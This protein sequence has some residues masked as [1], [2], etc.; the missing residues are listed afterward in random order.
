MVLYWSIVIRLQKDATLVGEK[1]LYVYGGRLLPVVDDQSIDEFIDGIDTTE[2]LYLDVSVNFDLKNPAWNLLTADNLIAFHSMSIGGQNNNSLIIFGGMSGGNAPPNPLYIFDT[3]SKSKSLASK[4]VTT[5]CTSRVLHTSVTKY[6]SKVFIL[7]GSSIPVAGNT[8]VSDAL[9]TL[10]VYDS[11]T[12]V[13]TVSTFANGISHHTSTLLSDDLIYVIGGINNVVTV[14]GLSLLPMN[15]IN[16]YDTNLNSWSTKTVLGDNPPQR[17]GHRAVGTINKKIIIYG[18]R[19][20]DASIIYDDVLELDTTTL[21]WKIIQTGGIDKPPALFDHTM[22]M[23]G[24]NIIITYGIISGAA[25]I[26][27]LLIIGLI[28]YVC[29]RKEKRHNSYFTTPYGLN[30][31]YSPPLT[32]NLLFNQSPN[33]LTSNKNT[34]DRSTSSLPVPPPP[35]LPPSTL[36]NKNSSDSSKL[37]I[38]D[39]NDVHRNPPR[40]QFSIDDY[41]GNP[42][43]LPS[44][45]LPSLTLPSTLKNKNSF[46]SN[47]LTIDDPNDASRNSSYLQLMQANDDRFK[48]S[49]IA[50]SSIYTPSRSSSTGSSHIGSTRPKIDT[51][52][53][54]ITE[55]GDVTPTKFTTTTSPS[56]DII[57][58]INAAAKSDSRSSEEGSFQSPLFK[59]EILSLRTA[60]RLSKM[61]PNDHVDHD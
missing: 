28:I 8:E 46:D 53:N 37:T 11:L 16:I 17:R 12:D 39:P 18:G 6:D 50:T 5:E 3:T 32:G 55:S 33:Y 56:S 49:S 13:F 48:A 45:T 60:T 34:P 7:G 4:A 52:L 9:N 41:L 26:V 24:T 31:P 58:A 21:T 15:V 36:K 22:T 2:I 43:Q 42:Y 29:K 30:Q 51:Q 47:K 20:A 35:L 54:S 44:L 61:N 27:V 40:K 38:V 23:V 14:T 59:N 19:N 1:Y 25:F 10:C 57:A